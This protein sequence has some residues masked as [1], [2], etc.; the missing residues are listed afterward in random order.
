MRIFAFD[1]VFVLTVIIAVCFSSIGEES[2]QTIAKLEQTLNQILRSDT[3]LFTRLSNSGSQAVSSRYPTS[4]S[5]SQLSMSDNA[6]MVTIKGLA[7][8]EG[9]AAEVASTP[10][11]GLDPEVERGLF[12]SIVYLRADRRH[13]LSSLPS[14]SGAGS[15][16]GWSF[17]SDFI[18]TQ[19]SDLSVISLPIS[20][21]ELWDPE[22]YRFSNQIDTP[23][24]YGIS[25][26]TSYQECG[27]RN[28]TESPV[29]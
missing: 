5:Q 20:Y 15:K 8:S 29:K 3:D 22:K 6:S 11:F 24:N 7:P 10:A 27:I 2:Q 26:K 17:F 21:Q 12:S 23:P 25:V 1:P 18:L 13:S 4:E 28:N 16:Y 14:T 19:I 9:A